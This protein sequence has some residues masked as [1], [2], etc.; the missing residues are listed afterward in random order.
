[1]DYSIDA[2]NEAYKDEVSVDNFLETLKFF[3]PP[4]EIVARIHRINQQ[5]GDFLVDEE[6]DRIH[7]PERTPRKEENIPQGLVRNI[8][9][10][11]SSILFSESADE[12]SGDREGSESE[13]TK[14]EILS[15]FQKLISERIF[16][17]LSLLVLSPHAK[18]GGVFSLG[19]ELTGGIAEDIG[20]GFCMRREKD[21]YLCK[22]GWEALADLACAFQEWLLFER[23][24]RF[25]AEWGVICLVKNKPHQEAINSQPI[26]WLEPDAE[27][28]KYRL[29]EA[30]IVAVSG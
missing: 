16:D 18:Q 10:Q 25:V 26:V 12:V 22:E 21:N 6:L 29:E 2:T 30:E 11:L 14:S 3:S 19:E 28:F 9:R 27:E 17:R 23:G 7:S 13:L 24:G 4:L 1:M 20:L 15:F 5:I 8:I